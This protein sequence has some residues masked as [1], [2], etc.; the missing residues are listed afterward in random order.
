MESK[1]IK[2]RDILVVGLQPWDIAIGSNCKNV[3]KELS[4]FN[5]VL[6]VNRALDRITLIRSKDDPKVQTRLK[7]LKKQTDDINSI[8]PNFWTL[9]PRTILESVNW[10]PFAPVFDFVNKINNKR[11]AK[12]INQALKRLGFKN[13]LLFND[14]EFYRGQYL[15]ELL[16]EVTDCIY[17]SRDN[18][19]T[20]PFF[21]RHGKRLEPSLMAK[22]SMVVTNSDYLEDYGRKYNPRTYNILQGCDFERFFPATPFTMPEEMA[23]IKGPIIGYMGALI[24]SRLD[25]SILEHIAA[26]RPQWSIVLVGPEDKTFEKS[27]LHKMPNVHFLGNTTEV[28]VPQF[29]Q[30]FDVCLNP[31]LVNGMTIGNYPRKLDEYMVLEKPVVVTETL[32]MKLFEGYIYQCKTKEDYIINIEKALAEEPG[33][34]IR[35]ARKTF[36]LTH[37]WETSLGKMSD[38]YRALQAN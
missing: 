38:H 12:E 20:H 29:I 14:N 36:A 8:G 5:R 15:I 16:P 13:V 34:D 35:K 31:Q 17:Y 25:I 11:L 24:V 28:R 1:M 33:S 10:I 22:A 4:Q 9:D 21:V 32:A 7:S 6:Y 30:F 37:T 2:G 26:E 23:H 27:K 18:I 19:A 3:A